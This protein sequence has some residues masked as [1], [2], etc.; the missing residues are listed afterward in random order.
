MFTFPSSC[1]KC[2][3]LFASSMS[4]S[5]HS[6]Q[7]MEER[8][9][10]GTLKSREEVR[11]DLKEVQSPRQT[12][13]LQ[14]TN[15]AVCLVFCR[16]MSLYCREN[17]TADF[18][19]KN[20]S[21][22]SLDARRSSGCVHDL[23]YWDRF[24]IYTIP[25]VAARFHNLFFSASTTAI[26]QRNVENASPQNKRRQST[27]VRFIP[28]EGVRGPTTASSSASL[29][30][31]AVAR[32]APQNGG[33]VDSTTTFRESLHDSTCSVRLQIHGGA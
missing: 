28:A 2:H 20:P 3:H 9:D 29:H 6:L 15:V 33:L 26:S 16:A 24:H 7:H 23:T 14:L 31:A 21:G 13:S 8:D 18:L 19:H 11:H 17:S 30:H 25:H 10:D 1:K 32:R 27:C 5:L 12:G 22:C 4:L